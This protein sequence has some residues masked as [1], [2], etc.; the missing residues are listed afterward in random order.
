MM[1]LYE[2]L[3]QFNIID[4]YDTKYLA[5]VG[6]ST[7]T[8][9]GISENTNHI[10][11]NIENIEWDEID[12]I[13]IGH[14][15]E[16]SDL[17]GAKA[18]SSL[19]L[20]ETALKKGKY[21]YSFDDIFSEVESSVSL[22]DKYYSPTETLDADEFDNSTFGKL[23]KIRTPI[24][25][26]IGTSSMQGKFSLQLI[27]RHLF[28]SRGYTIAQLGS[29]PSS[30]LFGMDECY[31][32]GY[33]S[34]HIHEPSYSIAQINKKMHNLDMLDRDLIIV[35]CQSNILA[36]EINNIRDLTFP[37]WSFLQGT[38][39]DGVVL[40]INEYDNID[41]IKKSIK[42]AESVVDCKVIAIVLFPMTYSNKLS[43]IYSKKRYIST[44][45]F[46]RINN[47]VSSE[48]MLP[49]YILGNEQHM[50]MLFT[51]IINFFS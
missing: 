40:C 37:Q 43:G 44:D 4:V 15:K 16:M 14:T 1:K 46:N 39:P 21:V 5:R 50:D 42:F 36:S 35:G 11:K 24:L 25:E 18:I 12:T 31:H 13:I 33:G 28:Q 22:N 23:H 27:L 49:V 20:A 9:L 6:A 32:F 29:E 34:K 41:Y 47:L 19:E 38:Q 30:Y 45:E 3:L 10:I 48:I 7:D 51:D 2:N 17:I 8:L 26:I